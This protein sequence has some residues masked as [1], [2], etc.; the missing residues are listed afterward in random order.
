MNIQLT[1]YFSQETGLCGDVCYVVDEEENV[2]LK[3]NEEYTSPDKP[4][5]TYKCTVSSNLCY[6]C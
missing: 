2:V 6:S 5:D 3:E 1:Q 4:C